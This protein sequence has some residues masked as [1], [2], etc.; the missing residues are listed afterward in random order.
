MANFR[1][2]PASVSTAKPSVRSHR[3]QQRLQPPL[4]CCEFCVPCDRSGALDDTSKLF[5]LREV[6]HDSERTTCS[7]IDAEKLTRQEPPAKGLLSQESRG[8]LTRFTSEEILGSH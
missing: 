2:T 5:A 3:V 4:N 6:C 1:V 8:T 7:M